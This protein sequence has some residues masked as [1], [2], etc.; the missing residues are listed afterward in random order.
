MCIRDSLTTY[1][2]HLYLPDPEPLLLVWSAFAA[3]Y[4]AGEPVWIM[5]VGSPGSG[6]S[7]ML[8]PLIHL[9]DVHEMGAVT[10]AGLLSGTSD[11][12]L[13]K[14]F[15]GG[16]LDEIGEFGVIVLKDFGSVLAMRA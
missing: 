6:K 7:E 2:K 4:L 3:N 15:T 16:L 1:Q 5:I 10:E 11:A 8:Q 14:G 13:D 9:Q 12:D